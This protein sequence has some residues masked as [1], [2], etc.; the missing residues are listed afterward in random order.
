MGQKQSIRRLKFPIF[1][2]LELTFSGYDTK[3]CTNIYLLLLLAHGLNLFFQWI[4]S[5]MI[6][7]YFNNTFF[8][9]CCHP[10]SITGSFNISMNYVDEV[11]CVLYKK[12]TFVK[13][14]YQ[15]F[16]LTGF[17]T[18]RKWLYHMLYLSIIS[19][20]KLC[21]TMYAYVY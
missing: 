6:H 15:I 10:H 16:I 21:N 7:F 9:H 2:Q 5:Q 18:R 8:F 14:F 3:L 17:A 11:Q 4:I 1:H 20:R 13:N 19:Y 12:F